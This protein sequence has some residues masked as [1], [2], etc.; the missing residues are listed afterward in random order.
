MLRVDL[1]RLEREG[2][3]QVEGVIAPD[4]PLFE[5][6]GIRFRSPLNA[7]AVATFAGSGELV[8]RG[9]IQ[10]SLVQ[11]CRRCLTELDPPLDAELTLVFAPPDELGQDPEGDVFSLEASAT[12]L[13]LRPAICEE[14]ALSVPSYA[15][16]KEDCKGF[17]V[18][19]GTNLNEDECQCTEEETD[20]RWDVLRALGSD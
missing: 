16:C 14:L 11:E 19:C 17:C 2:V 8:V 7:K 15:F 5:E 3:L 12:E 1:V 9:R 13:D 20:S 6:L 4:D 10:G 18:R